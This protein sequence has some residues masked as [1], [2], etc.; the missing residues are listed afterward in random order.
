MNRFTDKV[1]LV[2]G[3]GSGI[4]RAAALAFVAE[5][6]AVVVT[7]RREAPLRALAEE[8]PDS[9]R[10]ITGDISAPGVARRVVDFTLAQFG[11]L[12]TVVNN[13]GV[14]VAK[15]LVE[16]TDD[17]IDLLL[18]VNVR[19]VLALT[20]EAVPALQKTRGSVVNVSSTAARASLP[21]VAA[22]AGTKAAIER[23]TSSLAVELGPLGVRVNAVAPGLTRTEMSATLPDAM[24]QGMVAQTPLGRLG[25]TADIARAITFLASDA[26]ITGQSLQSSGG[27]ML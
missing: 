22:Y 12:D 10:A 17:D 20:R 21:G 18:S 14:W 24:A 9:V 15:P 11:R 25:E 16:L 5:G 27:L 26:W 1:A 19:G 2:T 7:G 4:G 13:A 8:H 6:G 23:I 3:G